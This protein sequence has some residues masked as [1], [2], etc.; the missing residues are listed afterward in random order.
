MKDMSWKQSQAILAIQKH[1]SAYLLNFTSVMKA[2]V[3]IS[4]L[5]SVVNA[6]QTLHEYKI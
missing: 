2:K 3:P 6:E 4:T 1:Q 5:V